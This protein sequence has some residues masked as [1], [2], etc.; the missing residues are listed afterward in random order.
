M[1]RINSYSEDRKNHSC[2]CASQLLWSVHCDPNFWQSASHLPKQYIAHR[3]LSFSVQSSISFLLKKC[4]MSNILIL[5]TKPPPTTLTHG[6]F[7]HIFSFISFLSIHNIFV[8]SLK[9]WTT[10]PI[11]IF[12]IL[13]TLFEYLCHSKTFDFS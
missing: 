4:S 9:S 8:G 10:T 2:T 1:T 12:H 6:N 11:I 13:M 7:L 5:S 3:Q